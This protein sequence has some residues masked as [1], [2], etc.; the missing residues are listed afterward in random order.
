[1]TMHL[2]TIS[3]RLIVLVCY[4]S[5]ILILAGVLVLILYSGNV[6]QR[7]SLANRLWFAKL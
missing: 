7:E 5:I 6:W 2:S 1:M 4:F 3:T